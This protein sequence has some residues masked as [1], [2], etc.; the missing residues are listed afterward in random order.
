MKP[1]QINAGEEIG[2]ILERFRLSQGWKAEEDEDHELRMTAFLEILGAARIPVNL[3]DRLYRRVMVTRAKK[4][5]SGESVSYYIAPEE[6]V[7]EYFTL[8]NELKKQSES[9]QSAP[10]CS[11]DRNHIDDKGNTKIISLFDLDRDEIAP[12]F[13][14]RYDDYK[15]WRKNQA[16]LYDEHQPK[17]IIPQVNDKPRSSLFVSPV[18]EIIDAKE[19]EKLVL[20]YNE[21][22]YKIASDEETRKQ[23]FVIFDEGGNCFKYANRPAHTFSL[24]A[25]IKTIEQYRESSAK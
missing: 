8:Q 14:C 22:L 18:E 15:K 25:F 16:S 2:K 3:Y 6:M 12:C 9:E 4:K 11:N 20:E 19:A 21:L 10:Q 5:A 13:F 23:Y 24:K 1:S 17:T 7:A